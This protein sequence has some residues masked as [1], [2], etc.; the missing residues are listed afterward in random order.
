MISSRFKKEIAALEQEIVKAGEHAEQEKTQMEEYLKKKEKGLRMV[1]DLTV[2][3]III[4]EDILM[5]YI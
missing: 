1:L 4:M 3:N 2:M 5:I